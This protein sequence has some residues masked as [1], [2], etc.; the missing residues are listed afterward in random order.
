MA[1]ITSYNVC[2]T[3]L[4]RPFLQ[5]LGVHPDRGQRGLQLVGDVGDEGGLQPG[6]ALVAPGLPEEERAAEEDA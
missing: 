2:Y 5:H 1:R 6:I 3:K 4:L